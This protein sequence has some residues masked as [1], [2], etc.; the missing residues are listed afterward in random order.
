MVGGRGCRR[1]QESVPEET[2]C[3]DR[4]GCV[5][6]PAA[7]R[8]VGGE[9]VPEGSQGQCGCLESTKLPAQHTSPGTSGGD[10]AGAWGHWVFC[11]LN[12]APKGGGE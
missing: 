4:L 6:G 1:K 9:G 5:L 11:S 12:F 7:C 10:G 3:E 8:A 2:S